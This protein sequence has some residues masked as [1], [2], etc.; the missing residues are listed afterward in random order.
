MPMDIS[1]NTPMSFPVGL[2]PRETSRQNVKYSKEVAAENGKHD[3]NEKEMEKRRN[4]QRGLGQIY[5]VCSMHK[6]GETF[7]RI[8]ATI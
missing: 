6:S 3:Y 5:K 2:L 8:F 7:Q 4:R 1:V